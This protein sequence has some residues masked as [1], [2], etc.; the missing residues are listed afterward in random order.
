MITVESVLCEFPPPP[1]VSTGSPGKA[2]LLETAPKIVLFDIYGT[3]LAPHVGDL[4]QQMEGDRERQSF[5]YTARRLGFSDAVGRRW[6]DAFFRQV[7]A[8]LTQ[9]SAVGIQRGEVLIEN[10][11]RSLL[12]EAGADLSKVP[13]RAAAL[14][15]E[16]LANPVALFAGVKAALSSLKECGMLLGVASN[17]QFYTP[18]IMARLLGTAPESFF[19]AKW[20][21]FSY[22]LGF[23]K[24]DPHFF[25]LVRT[26][27]LR[28]G[29]QPRDVLMVG[30]DPANDIHCAALHG[31]Q[32]VL[33]DPQGGAGRSRSLEHPNSVAGFEEL[34]A[35]IIN[36][37]RPLNV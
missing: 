15:R 22:R 19:A 28:A 30:N 4:Q 14:Y 24:P 7:E 12:L 9:C 29:Y 13:P 33:F 1:A 34:T 35:A 31:L 25:R 17:A 16:M 10:I 5:V 32:T 37:R 27:V 23:A 36:S 21:F 18:L 3:L 8:E 26:C 6:A 11:W 20:T 2:L